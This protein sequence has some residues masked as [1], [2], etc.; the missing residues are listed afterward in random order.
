ML[1]RIKQQGLQTVGLADQTTDPVLDDLA[2]KFKNCCAATDK[3]EAAAKLYEGSVMGTVSALSQAKLEVERTFGA[4]DKAAVQLY[5]QAL[6]AIAGGAKVKFGEVYTHR[7]WGPLEEYKTVLDAIATRLKQRNKAQLDYDIARSKVKTLIQ[8]PKD[9]V[10]LQQA[11]A[12]QLSTKDGCEAG[13]KKSK[14]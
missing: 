12:T 9:A 14:G 2:L 10:T 11:E 8:K 13:R 5:D 1:G 7:A 4:E 6:Q 3:L